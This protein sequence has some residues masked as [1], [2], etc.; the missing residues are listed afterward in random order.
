M[1]SGGRNGR[2]ISNGAERVVERES[3]GTGKT[4]KDEHKSRIPGTE[5]KLLTEK[6]IYGAYVREG[7][8]ALIHRNTGKRSNQ[9]I[10]E[11]VREKAV[12]IPGKIPGFWTGAGGGE[13]ER[14]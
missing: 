11:A 5:H 10:N 3:D 14:R 8:K 7:D 13:A 4:G 2:E 6:R 12:S 9:R 1:F